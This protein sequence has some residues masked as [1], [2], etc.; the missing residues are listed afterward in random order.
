MPIGGVERFPGVS[1]FRREETPNTEQEIYDSALK[2]Y[3]AWN[4]REGGGLI[5]FDLTAGPDEFEEVSRGF[6][7]VATSED[8]TFMRG[9]LGRILQRVDEALPFAKENSHHNLEFL[10]ARLE[11]SLWFALRLSGETIDPL[12]YIE[13]TNAVRAEQTDNDIILPLRS[14][15]VKMAEEQDIPIEDEEVYLVWRKENQLDPESTKEL[16]RQSVE[17]SLAAVKKFTGG[18]S[19]LDYEINGVFANKYYYGWSRTNYE[20]LAFSLDLNLHST[21][22]W[23]PGKAEELGVHE[24]GE[25]L[26]R[27]ND[28]RQMI[29]KGK[30]PAVIGQTVV[31]G[32]ESV[33]EEG[34]ALTLAHF[35]PEIYEGLSP[36]G[37]FQVDASILRYLV[38]GNASIMLN[39]PDR[40][41]TKRIKE[42]ICGLLPWEPESD[43]NRQIK[44]RTQDA[45]FQ[46]YLPSYA[47]GARIFLEIIKTLNEHGRKQLLRD[48]SQKPYTPEQLANR[49]HELKIGK[50]KRE[51]V[52]IDNQT[53]QVQ[54]S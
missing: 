23:T 31:H 19:H 14:R 38:Y 22:I 21:K 1:F 42:Y 16:V 11:A 46:A 6:R 32:P 39:S 3:R 24:G 36:E 49:V 52:L 30:M 54:A 28:W 50:R 7:Q 48:L 4:V 9:V 47:F 18:D 12:V 41:S 45:T 37:K 8:R 2:A 27:M 5:D 10:R 25:H 44:W 51:E 40:H 33:I 17:K 43:I 29:R 26:R 34:L 20:T 53:L 13:K 15:V 35:V